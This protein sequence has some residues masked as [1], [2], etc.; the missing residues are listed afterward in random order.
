[1]DSLDLLK[2]IQDLQNVLSGE[3][4]D[5]PL[6]TTFFTI[7]SIVDDLLLKITDPT[8]RHYIRKLKK[9]DLINLHN[10]FGTEVSNEYQ[11]WH[12]DHPLTAEWHAEINRVIVDEV[13]D[14]PNHPDAVSNKIVELLH[15]KLQYIS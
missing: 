10:G 8:D 7:E 2:Q 9:K 15:R 14:S 4:R 5:P 3:H 6:T 11:L 1:M 13:D 12:S